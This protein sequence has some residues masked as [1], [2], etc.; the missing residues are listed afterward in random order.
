MLQTLMQRR[1]S[2]DAPF[3]RDKQTVDDAFAD[4]F[5]TGIEWTN[6]WKPG[7]PYYHHPD[8]R[9]HPDLIAYAQ[10]TVDRHTAWHQ[11]F[12]A[13]QMMLGDNG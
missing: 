7:G 11:G 6:P 1:P 3:R 5:F 9:D 10:L 2:D 12:K 13:A 4:G 8:P